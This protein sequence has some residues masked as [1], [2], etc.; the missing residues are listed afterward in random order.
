[1]AKKIYLVSM[2]WP[3]CLEPICICHNKQK[4]KR[5]ALQK[6]KEEHGKGP[7]DRPGAMCSVKLQYDDLDVEEIEFVE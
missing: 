1:M 5:W 2:V 6:L 4:G 3:R 7:V